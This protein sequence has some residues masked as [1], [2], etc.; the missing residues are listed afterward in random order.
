[1][2]LF[3]SALLL[4]MLLSACRKGEGQPCTENS[5][6]RLGLYCQEKTGMC[7]D[8]G[9]LLKE[10]AAKEYVYPIPVSPKGKVKG[11]RV[12]PPVPR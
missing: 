5:D 9:E 1:M 3:V 7:K 2:K 12:S 11:S 10:K 8:R 6:C 4:A